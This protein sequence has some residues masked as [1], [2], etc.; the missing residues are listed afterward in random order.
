[1]KLH[2]LS[3]RILCIAAF[4]GSL[5][6]LPPA[7]AATLS[8]E[9]VTKVGTVFLPPVDLTAE[10]TLDW[11]YWEETSTRLTTTVAPTNRKSGGSLISSVSAFNDGVGTDGVL[12]GSATGVTVGRYDFS[13]G[14][15][16]VSGT[17]YQLAGLLFNE[18]LGDK[19][20]GDGFTL[21][22]QGD[23]ESEQLVRL[24]LGGFGVAGKLQLTLAGVTTVVD[25]TQEFAATS[26]K[27]LAI[28]TVRFQPDS[29]NDLLTVTYTAAVPQTGI[30][31]TSGHVGL[32]AVT[33]SA[34]PEPSSA[35]LI[36]VGAIGF[37][38]TRRR[39]A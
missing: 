37:L 12:R 21:Q 13:D 23:P 5:S 16:Q 25:T 14:T 8:L 32:E 28:Y 27:N 20:V 9:S 15:T 1:M 11:A 22:I 19:S 17:N 3:A 30:V 36:G 7:V 4:A 29:I 39:R 24:Y 33:V 35:L 34:I 26:A 10:G 18:N 38:G 6:I 2:P 31:N